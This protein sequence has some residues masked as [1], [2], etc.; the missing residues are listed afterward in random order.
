MNTIYSFII[1][2]LLFSSSLSFTPISERKFKWQVHSF[3]DPREIKQILKKGTNLIKIDLYFATQPD[4]FTQDQRA[5]S[6]PRGC[7]LLVH[8]KPQKTFVYDTIYTY[9]D[10]LIKYKQLFQSNDVSYN[11]ALCFKNT[12]CDICYWDYYHWIDLVDDLYAYLDRVITENNMNLEVVYDGVKRDCVRD[13]WP[14]WTYTWIRGRDPDDAFTSNDPALH[15]DKFIIFN[16]KYSALKSDAEKDWG[17]FKNVNRPLQLWEPTHQ[18][19]IQK[20]AK[21]FVAHP[22]PIGYAYA[23]NI[24][25]S[26]YQVYTA[27]ISKENLK[28][29]I[30]KDDSFLMK[31]TVFTVVDGNIL[32]L[33]NSAQKYMM[34]FSVESKNNKITEIS[35]EEWTTVPQGEL[36]DCVYLGR[37]EGKDILVVDNKEGDFYVYEIDSSSHQITRARYGNYK[38]YMELYN[39]NFDC[40]SNSIISSNKNA[41]ITQISTASITLLSNNPAEKEFNVLV[42]FVDEE[43]K[44]KVVLVPSK[45]DYQLF[46]KMQPALSHS[47]PLLSTLRDINLKCANGNCLILYQYDNHSVIKSI[48]LTIINNSITV[49]NTDWKSFGVGGNF[50]LDMLSHN[51]KEKFF[52]VKDGGFCY[53]NDAANKG[54]YVKICD[55]TEVSMPHI[56][57]YIYGELNYDD[58]DNEYSSVC[59]KSTITGSY[60]MGDYPKV[61]TYIN[62]EGKYEF[63]VMHDALKKGTSV[64]ENCGLSIRRK[65]LV[66]DNWDIGDVRLD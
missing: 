11:L 26:M 8:D 7:F 32:Y 25:P 29:N 33:F 19:D 1:S 23:I 34:T 36:K 48:Y 58:A 6:D 4:C 60:D 53:H 59:S 37:V 54:A 5:Y 51:G 24:D 44:N 52:V 9:M 22:H 13:K 62:K 56:L 55:Q 57:N 47:I 65:G 42:A 10:E 30:I 21:I 50:S 12:P 3:N 35:K 14:K 16:D 15:Y 41:C 46:L 18:T 45:I 40:L 20:Y 49:M 63:T 64:N 2:L 66:A 28:Y 43:N 61:S 39:D 27:G 17:K 31:H 38:K